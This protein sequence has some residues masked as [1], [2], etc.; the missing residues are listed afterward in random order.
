MRKKCVW[1]CRLWKRGHFCLGLNVLIH[2]PT[3]ADKM[4]QNYRKWKFYKQFCLW[5]LVDFSIFSMTCN[6]W[7]MINETAWINDYIHYKV[8]DEITFL[9]SNFNGVMVKVWEWII[10]FIPHFFWACNYLYLIRFKLNH[11]SKRGP[12]CTII[13]QYGWQAWIA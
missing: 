11:I 2:L 12:N 13:Y 9:F 7:M 10:D 6:P 8:W 3:H 4:G 1:K 5:K